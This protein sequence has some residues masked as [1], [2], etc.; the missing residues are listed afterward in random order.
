MRIALPVSKQ[1]RAPKH[2]R[3]H[4]P[5]CCHHCRRWIQGPIVQ[6][7]C[8]DHT[9]N[10]IW[11]PT[12]DYDATLP[13]NPGFL[14]GTGRLCDVGRA[15]GR[16]DCAIAS[17]RM[18]NADHFPSQRPAIGRPL[19]RR[20]CCRTRTPQQVF[21]ISAYPPEPNRH[22]EHR[23]VSVQAHDIV[24]RFRVDPG[25][26]RDSRLPRCVQLISEQGRDPDPRRCHQRQNPHRR[27][28]RQHTTD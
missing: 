21:P 23:S 3:R 5:K 11:S 13:V 7:S 2:S 6:Q 1:G 10:T 24:S 17:K 14:E 27:H 28:L 26:I 9:C 12:D 18:A 8:D 22:P 4:P 16:I 15:E 20:R 25:S 19:V